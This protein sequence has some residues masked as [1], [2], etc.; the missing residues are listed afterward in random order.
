MVRK[1]PKP[2]LRMSLVAASSNCLRVLSLRS[3][4]VRR[5]ANLGSAELSRRDRSFCRGAG[6]ASFPDLWWPACAGSLEF[7]IDTLFDDFDGEGLERNRTRHAGGLATRHV[8]G[9]EVPGAF[10]D[11]PGKGAF[12]R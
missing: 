4:W 3:A 11:L 9:A 1:P 8:E 5:G 7:D 10:D 12:L 6:T 2:L